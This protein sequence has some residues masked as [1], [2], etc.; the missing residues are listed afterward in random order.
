VIINGVTGRLVPPESVDELA[1]AVVE[2]IEQPA[3]AAAM[4]AEGRRRFTDPFRI[5]TMV[6]DTERLYHELLRGRGLPAPTG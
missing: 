4:A 5:E 1:D 6:A 2:M 3:R